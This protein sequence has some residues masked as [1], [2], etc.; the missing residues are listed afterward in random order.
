MTKKISNGSGPR[1]QSKIE[2]VKREINLQESTI[3]MYRVFDIEGDDDGSQKASEIEI[4]NRQIRFLTSQLQAYS[5][6][7][8]E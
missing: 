2:K 1:K 4:A 3:N 5:N 8:N 6:P 7:L